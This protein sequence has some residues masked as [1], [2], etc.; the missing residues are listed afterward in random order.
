MVVL[1]E[2]PLFVER[3]DEVIE[4]VCTVLQ[5]ESLRATKAEFD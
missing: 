3:S 1:S 4:Q 2:L 5:C